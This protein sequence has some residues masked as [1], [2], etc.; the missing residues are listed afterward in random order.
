MKNR[1]MCPK[2]TLMLY[3]NTHKFGELLLFLEQLF[4]KCSP[5]TA[6]N[7]SLHGVSVCPQNPCFQ[8]DH[9]FPKRMGIIQRLKLA[10][11]DPSMMKCKG[12]NVL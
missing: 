11:T 9:K 5:C 12:S 1:I 10:K 2:L 6:A 4:P 8:I 3:T 7:E